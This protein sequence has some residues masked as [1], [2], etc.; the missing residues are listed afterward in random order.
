M[1][2]GGGLSSVSAATPRIRVWTVLAV[3]VCMLA[4]W[5]YG[6]LYSSSVGLGVR[7]GL[8]TDL[9]PVW[10]GARAVLHGIDPYSDEVTRQNEVTAYGATA[11]EVGTTVEQRFAYP[12]YAVAPWLPFGL[13]PYSVANVIVF[14]LYA[15][16]VVLL[17]GWIRGKWDRTTLLYV[18]LCFCSYPILYDLQTRQPTVCYFA[19]GV[20][21][22]ALLRR[23]GLVTAG[24]LLALAAGKPQI[25][26]PLILPML[27]WTVTEWR[28]RKSF[29]LGFGITWA[30][31]I[32]LSTIA[33]PHWIPEW[34]SAAR[35]YA[36]YIRPP[37]VVS[38]FGAKIGM[39]VSAV[40]FLALVVTLWICRRSELLFQL[41]LSVVVLQFIVPYQ[42]YNALLLL[43]PV[44]QVADSA[45]TLKASEGFG[46]LA[47]AA[48]RISLVGLWTANF[49]G[50]IL[51][52]RSVEWQ[53][54]AWG[55][56]GAMVQMLLLA[57][58]VT[59]SVQV[60]SM[61]QLAQA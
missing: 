59:M 8:A 51:W 53:L 48:V 18:A 54:I 56:P 9:F 35:L 21:G 26:L 13:I 36:H 43:I 38:A 49:V 60:Y 45:G 11:R 32:G 42:T 7:R 2:A 20:A 37:L 30:A 46:Q 27:I 16:L 44:I 28:E 22:M 3:V 19:L 4:C 41:S 10:N 23:R 5:Y 17:V 50:I 57:L 40:S 33:A 34:L 52:R 14:W 6:V 55:L 29:A 61:Y 1:P 25:A 24:A 47:L 12:V 31:L 58:L 15:A 39:L